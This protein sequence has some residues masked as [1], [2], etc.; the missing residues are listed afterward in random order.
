MEWYSARLLYVQ[1]EHG[2]PQDQ[3]VYRSSVVVFI[4]NSATEARQRALEL[5]HS[6]EIMY[7]ED[8]DHLVRRAFVEL[9]TVDRIGRDINGRE[10]S[11]YEYRSANPVSFDEEFHPELDTPQQTLQ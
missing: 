8:G 2:V 5:G 11:A 10:V 9:Q 3:Y 4:A 1:L 7:R 6:K